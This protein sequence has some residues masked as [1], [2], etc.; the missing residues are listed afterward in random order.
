MIGFTGDRPRSPFWAAFR[1]SWLRRPDLP[2]KAVNCGTISRGR[3][4]ADAILRRR[5]SIARRFPHKSDAERVCLLADS[6]TFTHTPVIALWGGFM[7]ANAI[8]FAGILFGLPT[9]I[10]ISF[11]VWATPSLA[12]TA[13]QQQACMGDAFR[14]CGSEIPYVSRVAA[15][16]AR[17]QSQ[18]SPGCRVYFRP[19]PIDPSAAAS[20]SVRP[21]HMRKWHRP[22]KQ[23]QHDDT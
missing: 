19:E 14:L 9:V 15:C 11:C 12:Y 8:R 16:M 22:R 3:V 23:I 7:V 5:A 21:A 10:A 1:L 18:L 4:I 6:V 20:I 17:Q 13:E 2:Q